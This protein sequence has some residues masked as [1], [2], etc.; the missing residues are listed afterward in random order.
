VTS[1][2]THAESA[3]VSPENLGV[4]LEDSAGVAALRNGLRL[5]ARIIGM[6]PLRV[7]TIGGRP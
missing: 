3:A 4:I 2:M 6:I 5:G 7:F 1:I